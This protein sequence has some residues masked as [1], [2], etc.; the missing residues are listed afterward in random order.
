ML[1]AVDIG[2]S[3]I[4]F[5]IYDDDT[6]LSRFTISTDRQ[7]SPDTLFKALTANVTQPITRAVICS[8]VPELNDPLVAALTA[9]F[10]VSALIV[11]NDFNLGITIDYRPLSAAGTDRLVNVFSA[12]V[13]YGVPVIVCSLG[14]ALTIDVVSG[15][16]VLVG[17]LIAPGIKPLSQALK[18][19]TSQLPEVDIEVP[20]RIIQNTTIGSIQ[21]GIFNGYVAMVDGLLNKIKSEIESSPRV[22]ATGGFAHMIAEHIPQIAVVDSDLTLDGLMLLAKKL[23]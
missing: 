6:L 16:K 13:K 23:G 12:T 11:K 21:S 8:V 1:L 14:T 22:V 3:N 20:K 5:G 15:E 7:A 18:L 2:N 4:K 9:A 19:A 10:D 17:G